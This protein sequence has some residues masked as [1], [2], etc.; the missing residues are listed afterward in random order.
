ML[1]DIN[2]TIAGN[3]SEEMK[4]GNRKQLELADCLGLS[5]QT[6]SMMLKGERTISAYEL[7]AISIF[8]GVPMN[9]LVRIPENPQPCDITE[10]FS[11][12]ATTAESKNLVSFAVRLS[13]MILFNRKATESGQEGLEPW[14]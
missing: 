10:R 14:V 13:D 5:K 6:V 8:L 7:K 3:I 1:I 2:R 4:K 11:K 9:T 12:R